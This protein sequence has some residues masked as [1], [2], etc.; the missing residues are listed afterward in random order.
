MSSLS[1]KLE[2]H[3][4]NVLIKCSEEI[5][6]ILYE[7]DKYLFNDDQSKEAF[8]KS[9][10]KKM[11]KQVIKDAVFNQLDINEVTEEYKALCMSINFSDQQDY[12]VTSKKIS[13]F[14]KDNQRNLQDF[15]YCE[16]AKK[17]C[18]YLNYCISNPVTKEPDMTIKKLCKKIDYYAHINNSLELTLTGKDVY[19]ETSLKNVV[20]ELE[21]YKIRSRDLYNILKIFF[22]KLISVKKLYASGDLF[23]EETESEKYYLEIFKIIEDYKITDFDLLDDKKMEEVLLKLE[24]SRNKIKNLINYRNE[25]SEKSKIKYVSTIDSGIDRYE[26]KKELHEKL[27]KTLSNY[28]ELKSMTLKRFLNREET[29]TVLNIFRE[30]DYSEEVLRQFIWD[31]E[32]MLVK[33]NLIN[34]CEYILKKAEFY[35]SKYGF[36]K[37]YNEFE[38]F[39]NRYLES[40]NSEDNDLIYELLELSYRE[41][42]HL[43]RNIPRTYEYELS[44]KSKNKKVLLLEDMNNN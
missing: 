6:D 15:Q 25:N 37:E 3:F 44:I 41:I 22:N 10:M 12:T 18:S 42:S 43:I 31:N 14:L 24:V 27:R 34:K 40:E 13:K 39:Y 4:S 30:L 2:D 9:D 16:S 26:S 1:V 17:L 38:D 19:L 33:Q 29:N 21:E 11:Y 32:S 28:F 36:E 7:R 23:V 35:S 5:A 20:K 8:K